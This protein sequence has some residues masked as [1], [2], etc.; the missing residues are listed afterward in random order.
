M[1]RLSVLYPAIPDSRFDWDYYLGGHIALAHRLL[2]PLGLVR[3][4]IDHGIG[5]FPP[6]AAPP[7]HAVGH[8]FFH[9]LADLQSAL[10][11]NAMEF[12]A[13]QANYTEIPAQVLIS[14]V[15]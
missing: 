15:V 8:L 9:T 5:S 1:V 7:F 6:G 13:D 3:I 10:A 4:E 11:A 12:I 14:E 2:D